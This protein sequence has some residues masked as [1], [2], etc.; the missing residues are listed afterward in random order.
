[1]VQEK[2]AQENVGDITCWHFFLGLS[3]IRKESIELYFWKK[4]IHLKKK[5]RNDNRKLMF[6]AHNIIS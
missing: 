2:K 5:K 4:V 3:Y 6:I 1:M